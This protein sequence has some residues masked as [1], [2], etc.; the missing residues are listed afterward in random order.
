ME[1]RALGPMNGDCG[2]T[3]SA[4]LRHPLRARILEV[5]NSCDISPVKFVNGEMWPR[6]F[7]FKS[8]QHA[9]SHVSYH[10]RALERAGCISVVDTHQR[11]GATE[12]VFRGSGSHYY[13]DEEFARMSPDQRRGLSLSA[14]Q[15]LVARVD[16]ALLSETLDTRADRHV[17]VTPMGLDERG[18]EELMAMMGRCME[19]SERIRSAARERLARSGDE[20]VPVTF[21]ILG[22][23]SPPPAPL[24]P[25]AFR[26]P[27]SEE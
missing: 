12:H 27:V 20:P 22:F 26:P 6:G 10:F 4:A 17:T 9:L 21:S 23:E 24:G 19:E 25:S 18:W 11:R 13:S 8:R 3:A 14:L 2:Q 1:A 15:S 5:A 7:S 16:C